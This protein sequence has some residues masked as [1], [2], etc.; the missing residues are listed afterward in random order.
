MKKVSSIDELKW[1][2]EKSDKTEFLSPWIIKQARLFLRK[3]M[4]YFPEEPTWVQSNYGVPSIIVRLDCVV[5]DDTL[6]VY[7]I[8]ERPAGIGIAFC[9]NDEFRSRLSY[10]QEIWPPLKSLVSSNRKESDDFLWIPMISKE[11]AEK[12][13]C[14]LLIRAE[15]FEEDFHIFQKR[16]VSTLIS[17]GD[18]AYGERIKLW[19][20]VSNYDFDDLPWL[21]GFCLKPKKGSKCRGVHIWNPQLKNKRVGVSTRSQILKA[22]IIHEEMYLQKYIPP[23]IEMHNGNK[24]LKAYRVYFGYDPIL[25]RYE[26]LGGIWIARPNLRIHGASDAV[27]GPLKIEEN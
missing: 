9:L 3:W 12:R 27:M 6:Y 10:L 14:L 8:E 11:E 17:K 24:L 4:N 19:K 13:D 21:T 23:M 7:E 20:I 15:P 16:S 22:L 18:K 26:C 25:G 1:K 2:F 5:E